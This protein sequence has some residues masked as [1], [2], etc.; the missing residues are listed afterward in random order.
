M[1]GIRVILAGPGRRRVVCS[2][3]PSVWVELPFHVANPIE[4]SAPR[5]SPSIP[6]PT[7]YV[8]REVLDVIPPRTG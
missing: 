5:H 2:E 3:V 1:A 8:E 7:T 6:D 4:E